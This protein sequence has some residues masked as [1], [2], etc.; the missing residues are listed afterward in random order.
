[1]VAAE[2]VF[3]KENALP[4]AEGTATACDRDAQRG[5]GEGGFDVGRHVVRALH[6]MDVAGVSVGDESRKKC[7][8]VALHVTVGVLVDDQGCDRVMNELLSEPFGDAG[9]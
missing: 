6:R 8:E 3:P 4:G 5:L 2:A 9:L 7:V 1:M